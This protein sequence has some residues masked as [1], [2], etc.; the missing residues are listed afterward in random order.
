MTVSRAITYLSA[1]VLLV[2][3]CER[4]TPPPPFVES[5]ARTVVF[6]E[7]EAIYYGDD[8][9]TETSDMWNIRLYGPDSF[10]QISCNTV[11]QSGIDAASL[12]GVY[13]AS[14]ENGKYLP[15]TFNPGY[16][17]EVDLSDYTI[18]APVMSYYGDISPD[19]PDFIPDLLS[20][21]YMVVDINDDNTFAIEGTMIGQ[22]FLKRNFIYEGDITII[23]RSSTLDVKSS[24]NSRYEI[25]YEVPSSAYMPDGMFLYKAER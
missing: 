9:N 14:S 3:G 25:T 18:K 1:L 17:I 12:E 13:S 16:M 10:I 23:D 2:W 4:I 5:V 15:D 24:N 21:G 8:G 7:A 20:E 22:S 6:T 11:R 19:S